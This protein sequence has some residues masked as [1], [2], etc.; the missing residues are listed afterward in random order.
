MKKKIILQK[1]ATREFVSKVKLFKNKSS[2]SESV[3]RPYLR[4]IKLEEKNNNINSFTKLPQW[5]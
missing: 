2:H 1:I 3:F 5:G 4:Q